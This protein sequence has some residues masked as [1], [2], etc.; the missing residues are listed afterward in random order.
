M[1][2]MHL[3]SLKW[4]HRRSFNILF[5][6]KRKEG[7]EKQASS[8]I[9]KVL[10]LLLRKSVLALLQEA[11]RKGNVILLLSSSPDFL[12]EKVA[13][14]LDIAHVFASVYSEDQNRCFAQVTVMD[15][16]R[17]KE[18]LKKFL[19]EYEIVP[20]NIIVY[21]DSYLDMPILEM[22]T[23]PLLV[24]PDRILRRIAIARKWNIIEA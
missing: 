15:G 10:P 16:D 7:I 13:K 5:Y 2:T 9:Q 4:L 8:F 11:Q 18:T 6:K 20:K 22:A 3:F 23:V 14:E 21:T 17:K 24:C 19:A 1:H 12:V